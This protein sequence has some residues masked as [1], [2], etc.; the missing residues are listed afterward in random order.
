MLLDYIMLFAGLERPSGSD[1]SHI[2][3]VM[4]VPQKVLQLSSQKPVVSF[5]LARREYIACFS[6]FLIK[7]KV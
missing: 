4:N 5:F 6:H 2:T 3:Q 7:I 1:S